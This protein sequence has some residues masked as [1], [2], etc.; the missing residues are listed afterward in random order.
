MESSGAGERGDSPFP[1]SQYFGGEWLRDFGR[2]I[3]RLGNDT[4]CQGG[5]EL[6]TALSAQGEDQKGITV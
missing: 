1:E 2:R 6:F 4:P 3:I 5:K